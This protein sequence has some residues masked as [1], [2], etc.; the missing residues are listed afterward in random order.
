MI[1]SI[2]G[3]E[4]FASSRCDLLHGVRIVDKRITKTT[5]GFEESDLVRKNFSGSAL[6]IA[7]T[8]CSC[9]YVRARVWEG[10]NS[11]EAVKTN[12]KRDLD[13]GLCRTFSK[14]KEHKIFLFG[15]YS[16]VPVWNELF[17]AFS[18]LM[19]DDS[20]TVLILQA[21]IPTTTT[22]V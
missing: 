1:C 14:W 13:H 3:A 16:G 11:A 5:D 20:Q 21:T 19:E 4:G 2:K 9:V 12:Y 7:A 8:V 18:L 22:F 17:L 10:R 6:K 15:F